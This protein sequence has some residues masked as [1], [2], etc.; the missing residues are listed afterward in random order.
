MKFHPIIELPP[1]S[2]CSSIECSANQNILQLGCDGQGHGQTLSQ[3]A[4]CVPA[5][6]LPPQQSIAQATVHQQLQPQQIS[7]S[8]PQTHL[9]QVLA[10]VLTALTNILDL[11]TYFSCV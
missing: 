3:S 5:Q 11:I 1:S 10:S 2:S 4:S 7:N 9:S 6:A 8:Q